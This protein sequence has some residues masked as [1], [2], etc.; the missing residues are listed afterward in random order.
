V[1]ETP[2]AARFRRL[3]MPHMQAACN[4]ARRLAGDAH[5]GED[6]AQEAMLRAY[7]FFPRF[8]GDDARAW[9]L[10]IVRNTF[11]T[12]WRRGRM[13]AGWAV[14][15]EELHGHDPALAGPASAGDPERTVSRAQELRLLARALGEL[16]PEYREA[17]VLRELDDLSYKEIAAALGVPIGTVMS[18]LSRA[19]RLLAASCA[20]LAEGGDA[21][22]SAPARDRRAR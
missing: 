15:E 11:Y 12:H 3:A 22:P 6:I 20:R 8:E 4:L 2:D 13:R 17:I 7:R 1:T 9:I 14:Y 10:R 18:R 5:D 16:Q 21:M 19:R